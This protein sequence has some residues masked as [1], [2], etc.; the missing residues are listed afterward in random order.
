MNAPV[1]RVLGVTALSTGIGFS[2]VTPLF[3]FFVASAALLAVTVTVFRFARFA[4]ALYSP[5]ALMEPVVAFPPATPFTDHVT[6]VLLLPVT[7]AVQLSVLAARTVAL[8]GVTATAFAEFP[9]ICTVSFADASGPG[10]GFSTVTAMLPT[11][12]VVAV[13]VAR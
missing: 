9:T 3:P 12:P 4:G 6:L 11:W 5:A 10:L 7:V 1:P 2:S 13:P 8:G